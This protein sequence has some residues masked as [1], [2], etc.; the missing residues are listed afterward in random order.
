MSVFKIYQKVLYVIFSL[1]ISG[2]ALSAPLEVFVQDDTVKAPDVT[3]LPLIDG[4]GDD[5][6]W[7]NIKWQSIDQVWI[8]YGGQVDSSDYWGRYKMAWSATEN[9][10]YFLVEIFDD[11]AV[12]GYIK[13]VTADYYNFDITEVFID[14]NKSGGLHVFDGTGNVARQYGTNAENAFTYHMYAKFPAENE[15]T[16]EKNVM[17]IAG[18]DWSHSTN[19]DYASHFPEFAFRKTGNLYTREFSLIVYNDTYNNNNPAASRVQLQTGKI[20]GLS[21]AYC[22]NDDPNESPQARDNFF[23]SVWV[24]PEAYNNHWMD[25]DDFGTVLLVS[26]TGITAPNEKSNYLSSFHLY[27]NPA[28]NFV[29]LEMANDY[30]GKYTIKLFNIMGQEVYRLSQFKSN[31][32][33]QAIV[34]SQNLQAGVYFFEIILEKQRF[35][36]KIV[37]T[38]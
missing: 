30:F 16:T 24:R 11:I 29:Q 1:L 14:E 21:I 4:K 13:G 33:A 18:T 32:Q 19:P 17:D 2:A 5:A 23:G 22:E 28:T 7:Q 8:P 6:C 37:I 10:L 12:D 20:L 25:A 27:P 3:A 36:K 26:T 34:S 9:L 31:Q 35:V 15:V 38:K